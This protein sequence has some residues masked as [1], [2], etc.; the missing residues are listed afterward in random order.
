MSIMGC[1]DYNLNLLRLNPNSQIPILSLCSVCELC[2]TLPLL[3]FITQT[4]ASKHADLVSS[5][6]KTVRY[7]REVLVREVGLLA[8]ANSVINVG[9][10]DMHSLAWTRSTTMKGNLVFVGQRLQNNPHWIVPS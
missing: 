3:L 1:P 2:Q 5:R 10:S 9:G 7:K 6:G 4:N 8:R